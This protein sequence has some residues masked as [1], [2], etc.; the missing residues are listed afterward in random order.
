MSLVPFLYRGACTLHWLATHNLL[1]SPG[2][3][4]PSTQTKVA[5][6]LNWL[7]LAG[8][9]AEGCKRRFSLFVLQL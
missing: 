3:E 1:E 2:V 9:A 4:S 6:E 8:L 5:W 7:A